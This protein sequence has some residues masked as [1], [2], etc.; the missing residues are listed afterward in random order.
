MKIVRIA[1]IVRHESDITILQK[2]EKFSLLKPRHGMSVSISSAFVL[3][4]E[5]NERN[6]GKCIRNFFVKLLIYPWVSR[7]GVYDSRLRDPS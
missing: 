6:I 7:T 1:D 2:G 4:A 3:A 5:R